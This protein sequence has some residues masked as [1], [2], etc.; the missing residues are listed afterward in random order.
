M[1]RLPDFQAVMDFIAPKPSDN[2]R[3]CAASIPTIPRIFGGQVI[4]QSML[5]GNATV[6]DDRFIHSL[7]AHFLRP[8]D[9]KQ[10][11]VIKVERIRDGAA[12]STRRVDILQNDKIIFICS[13]NYHVV[14]PGE[15]HEIAGP[16]LTP[17]DKDNAGHF[18]PQN[19]QGKPD[20]QRDSV[21]DLFRFQRH[22]IT[23]RTAES[24][25]PYQRS[26][27]KVDGILDRDKRVHQAALG[28]LSDYA[29]LS[30]ALMPLPTKN[31]FADYTVASLDHTMWFH[32]DAR[33]DEFILYDCD[34]P[35]AG[36]SRGF[37][38]GQ[39]R[40]AEG[41]LIASSAQENLMRKK[42]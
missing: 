33:A 20:A 25:P 26:W 35:W 24:Q 11:V 8:G 41:V 31:F 2:D 27:F 13:L 17:P 23:P 14:E 4:A 21:A 28:M 6:T 15:H 34:S 9:S 42:Y 38:R 40:T 32:N 16:A 22:P 12:F 3:F 5:A 30:T 7:H 18:N 29:L 39:L 37:S 36:G 10:D 19:T 1:E